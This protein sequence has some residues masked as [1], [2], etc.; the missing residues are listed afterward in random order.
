M[1]YLVVGQHPWNKALYLSSLQYFDGNWFYFGGEPQDLEWAITESGPRYIFF[2]HW[3]HIVPDYLVNNYECVCFHPTDLPYGRGG[4]PVQNLIERGHEYTYLTSFRMTTELDAGP[5]YDKT[6][7]SLLGTAQEI[8]EDMMTLAKGQIAYIVKT[9]PTPREQEGTP[10]FFQRRK[11]E[12]SRLTGDKTLKQ[13]YDFIRMLDA[14]GYP[15]AFIEDGIS[16]IEFTKARLEK[17]YLI[18][19]ARVTINVCK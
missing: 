14:E 15:H 3:S 19:T 5:I 2:L 6:R 1:N 18:T 16:R 10:T 4:T 12:D 11:P 8:Y 17:D 9:N 7:L 13:Q